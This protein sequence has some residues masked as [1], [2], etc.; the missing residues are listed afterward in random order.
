MAIKNK[1]ARIEDGTVQQ[2]IVGTVQ[3]AQENLGGEWVDASDVQCG[4]GFTYDGSKFIPPKPFASWVYVE[5]GNYWKA[6]VDHP[7]EEDK[8]YEWDEKSLSWVEL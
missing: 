6:P 4:A 8:E 5:D 3:W 2:V 1:A 7:M